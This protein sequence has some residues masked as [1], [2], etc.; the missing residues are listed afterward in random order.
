VI[1]GGAG[2][3]FER[4]LL[5]MGHSA[6]AHLLAL[7]VTRADPDQRPD[8]LL[9]AGGIYDF[10]L[11]VR[12]SRLLQDGLREAIGCD[13]RSCPGAEAL[14][15]AT[16]VAPGL[17]PTVLVHG[18]ADRVT[19]ADGTTKF[20]EALRSAGV[21]V[22]VRMVDGGRHRNDRTDAAVAAALADLRD[23]LGEERSSR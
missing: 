10:G 18:L 1:A 7:A 21:D 17:P 2:Q 5:G 19:P 22:T 14:S 4:P 12:R 15:P 13:E 11:Q 23:Q 3:A 16:W 8:A 20:A 9:L 6:G